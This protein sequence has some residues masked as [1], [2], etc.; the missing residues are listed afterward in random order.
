MIILQYS[1]RKP[2]IW[3]NVPENDFLA[4]SARL[5]AIV[6]KSDKKRKELV[7][8]EFRFNWVTIYNLL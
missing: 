3:Q 1:T 2:F 4:E 5:L 8:V 6:Q 7:P